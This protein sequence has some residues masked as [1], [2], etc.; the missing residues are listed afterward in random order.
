MVLDLGF[1]DPGSCGLV[2]LADHAAEYLP[3]PDRKV[4]RGSGLGFPVGWPLLAGLMQPVPVVVAGV[5]TEDRPQ[6]PFIVDEHP[7]DALGSCGAYPSFGVTVRPWRLRRGLD[8]FQ[9]LAG[10]DFVEG[11]RE[12]GVTVPDEEAQR[13][14]RSPRSMTRLR[15][16]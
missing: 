1:H 15:A 9:A 14:A 7:V 3:P 13:S 16:C 8:Y 10:E 6:V 2:V 5:L 12:L 11:G 4:Q